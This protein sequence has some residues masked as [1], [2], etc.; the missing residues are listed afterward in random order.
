MKKL[1]EVIIIQPGYAVWEK[2]LSLQRA[3]GTI[4]LVK[5]KQNIIVDTGLPHDKDT[6]LKC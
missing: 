2:E 3:D 1:A 5:S 6:I 4:T